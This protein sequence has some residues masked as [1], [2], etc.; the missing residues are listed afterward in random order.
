MAKIVFLGNMGVMRKDQQ[1]ST[2]V[3]VTNVARKLEKAG[4]TCTIVYSLSESIASIS[5]IIKNT[6]LVFLHRIQF[7][8]LTYVDIKFISALLFS[9]KFKKKII[10]DFDDSIFLTYPLITDIFISCANKVFVGSHY[11]YDYSVRRKSSTFLIPSAVDT[12]IFNPS[13][14]AKKNDKIVIGWHGS[15]FAHLK[16]LSSILPVIRQIGDRY[17]VRVKLLGTRGALEIQ[18]YFREKVP[19]VEFDFGPE[20]WLSY[21]K[22]PLFMSDIDIS[23]SP[24]LDSPWTRGK[25]AMKTLESMALGIPVVADSVGEHKYVIKNGTTGFLAANREDW[26]TSLVK[27]IDDSSLRQEISS[28]CRE[29]VVKNYSLDAISQKVNKLIQIQ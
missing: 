25:C 18:N 3:R 23:V 15:I 16:N 6:D 24:L 7:S 11:L 27:L 14:N 9:K 1:Q 19:N 17:D 8:K 12:N 28:N 13:V 21:E 4:H 2:I 5:E 26:I 10:F 20:E 22:L 29:F